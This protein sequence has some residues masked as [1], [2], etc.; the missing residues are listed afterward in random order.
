MQSSLPEQLFQRAIFR[1]PPMRW[2]LET[3]ER[4][5]LRRSDLVVSSTGLAE[6]VR[7]MAPATEVREWRFSGTA[8]EPDADEACALRRRLGLGSE[9]RVVLYSG[10][11]EEYQGLNELVGA[12]PTVLAEFP[13]TVFVLVGAE[14]DTGLTDDGKAAPLLA[15]GA[16]RVIGRQ[17]RPAMAA[18]HALADV[19]VSPRSYGGNLPLKVFDYLAAGRPI[20]ATDLPTHRTVLSEERAVLVTP[21]T[22]AIAEGILSLLRDPAR[23]ARLAD[24]ARTYA[25]EHLAWTAWV[26]CVGQLYEDVHRHAHGG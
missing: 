20:V 18:Y 7:R 8:A 15:S 9:Q 11:F 3:A 26:R 21:E 2:I 19:L 4:W 1:L 14:P 6:R 16:L 25:E 10:T 17:P 13:D 5:L 12:I 22:G 24:A 23:A